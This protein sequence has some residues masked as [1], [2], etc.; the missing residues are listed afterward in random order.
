MRDHSARTGLVLEPFER[1]PL[2]QEGGV[3]MPPFPVLLDEL[4]AL[5]QED[6]QELNV[7]GVERVAA[8]APDG[9]KGAAADIVGW[10]TVDLGPG[11][12]EAEAGAVQ[13]AHV[14]TRTTS[15][16]TGEGPWG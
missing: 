10:L 3:G 7:A 11:G 4:T 5:L 1:S 6:L 16:P 8:E 2:V 14:P 12:S 13:S 9:T 15:G